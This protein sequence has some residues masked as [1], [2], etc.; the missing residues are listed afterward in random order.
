M[1][2]IVAYENYPDGSPG[3][4]RVAS[5]AG[6]YVDFGY[7]VVVIHKG[8][9]VVVKNNPQEVSFY[10]KN[11]Y[12]KYFCFTNQVIKQLNE[13]KETKQLEAVITF[14]LFRKVTRWCNKHKVV[15][16]TDEV[17]WYSKEQFK[18]WYLSYSYWTKEREIHYLVKNKCRVICISSFLKD[19]FESHGS[20]AI[21]IPIV[22][23]ETVPFVERKEDLRTINLIYAGS[24]LLMDNIPIVIKSLIRL[25]EEERKRISFTIY[26]LTEKAIY[27][28]LTE[29]EIKLTKNCLKILGRRPNKEILDA[30]KSSHFTIL[31]RNPL[32]RVNK[33]GF[34][35]KIV[36]SMRMGIPILGNYSS[37]L[38]EYLIDGKNAII[39]HELSEEG[40]AKALCSAL[41]LTL[42]QMFLLRKN[43]WETVRLKLQSKRFK[44]QFIEII[45]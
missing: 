1:I 33:A 36:E 12:R 7:D 41:H 2:V 3:A 27:Q 26:G 25:S 43:A 40:I 13:L 18:H 42:E 10:N 19:Y 23:K 28:F 34:P 16:A 22:S 37:D 20:K 44:N 17:E 30:Y 39:V 32:L 21:Q 5:F 6:A 35:S 15:C 9:S 31:L 8:E 29:E 45:K 11:K 14:G 38:N 4:F 24:H